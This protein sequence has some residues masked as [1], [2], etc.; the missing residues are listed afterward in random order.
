MREMAF[1]VDHFVLR[2]GAKA[3]GAYYSGRCHGTSPAA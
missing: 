3:T 1:C 2:A